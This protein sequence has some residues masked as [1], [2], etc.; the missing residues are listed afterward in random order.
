MGEKSGKLRAG[1]AE[2]VASLNVMP[3][4]N[5]AATTTDF[6]FQ[7][8]SS[9]NDTFLFNCTDLFNCTFQNGTRN[10]TT[11]EEIDYEPLSDIILMGILS[12]VLGLM[13]L[14]TVIGNAV[15]QANISTSRPGAFPWAAAMPLRIRE[16]KVYIYTFYFTFNNAISPMADSQERFNGFLQGNAS[17]LI[18]LTRFNGYVY[19]FERLTSCGC[20]EFNEVNLGLVKGNR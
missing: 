10:F 16:T 19:G 13:I 9:F 8:M 7:N 18:R 4:E 20:K 2:A 5:I 3:P 15:L 14:I 17:M 12:I 11:V 1:I 6:S